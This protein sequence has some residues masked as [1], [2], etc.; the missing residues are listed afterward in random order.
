M[1]IYDVVDE[2][3]CCVAEYAGAP[4]GVAVDSCTNAIKLCLAYDKMFHRWDLIEMPKYTYVGVPYAV[5]AL[6]GKCS[7]VDEEWIGE[8]GF[9][10]RAN[11]IYSDT[12]IIDSA[13]RFRKGMYM[14]RDEL[15]C[16]S[17][18][19]TKHLPIGRGGMI[20][21]E[22][23]DAYHYLRKMRFDGR[24]PKTAADKD[25][26]ITPGF[27]CHMKPD[28]AARG[29]MLMAGMPDDNEDLPN[30]PYPDLSQFPIFQ[31]G[32]SWM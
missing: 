4:Y 18:H 27:H 25:K 7:F 14:G 5:L 2:F 12:N 31:D 1:H 10:A 17:F 6:G 15:R 21:T 32:Y 8:Y 3:E 23:E 22:N 19:E 11:G 20:L 30:S 16:L 9:R 28:D 29:L 13:R 24:T 26:F